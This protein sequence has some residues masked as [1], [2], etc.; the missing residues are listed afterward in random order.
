[1]ASSRSMWSPPRGSVHLTLG[2][3]PK[4][5]F[6]CGGHAAGIRALPCGSA[7]RHACRPCAVLTNA[8]HPHYAAVELTSAMQAHLCGDNRS[9]SRPNQLWVIECRCA[10]S[11]CRA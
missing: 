5:H 6:M 3:L 2:S 11:W 10:A 9:A 8:G 7:L 4:H 1:M